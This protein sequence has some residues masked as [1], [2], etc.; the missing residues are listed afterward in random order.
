MAQDI[1]TLVASHDKVFDPIPEEVG[2]PENGVIIQEDGDTV[3]LGYITHD[4][5]PM[6]FWQSADGL[7]ELKLFKRGD[8]PNALMEGH[9]A[10]GEAPLLVERYAHGAEHYSVVGTRNY[11]DRQWDVGLCGIFLP[12][13]EV[14]KRYHADLD[15]DAPGAAWNKLV[16]DSNNVLSEFSKTVNGEVYGIVVEELR[17]EGDALVRDDYESVWGH[18]GSDWA[19]EALGEMMPD[20]EL[21]TPA[22]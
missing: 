3:R 20:P 5:E 17:R 19:V 21:E 13:E 2:G 12:C 15:P 14:T 4:P 18:I 10:R 6:D 11:P 22:P 16:E 7:G 8:D 1:K 9:R